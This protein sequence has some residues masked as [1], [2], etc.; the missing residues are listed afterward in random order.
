MHAAYVLGVLRNGGFK[1]IGMH[2]NIHKIF[3]LYSYSVRCYGVGLACIVDVSAT[4]LCGRCELL[5]LLR[6]K[7][8]S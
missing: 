6:D 8:M 5:S 7:L 2:E 1:E 4:I 3:K